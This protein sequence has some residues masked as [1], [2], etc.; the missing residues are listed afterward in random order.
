MSN[1]YGRA[2]KNISAVD[3][4]RRLNKSWQPPEPRPFVTDRDP[5]KDIARTPEN[6]FNE[7]GGGKRS[8]K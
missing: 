7:V 4:T 6:N 2:V 3:Y 8:R 5:Y 1:G